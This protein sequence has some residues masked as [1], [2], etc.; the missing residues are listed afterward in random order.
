MIVFAEVFP[1]HSSESQKY[2]LAKHLP[3]QKYP[4]IYYKPYID[5]IESVASDSEY[6]ATITYIGQR[7]IE[8]GMTNLMLHS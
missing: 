2:L 5:K 4:S 8:D 6:E 1:K 7:S 3:M